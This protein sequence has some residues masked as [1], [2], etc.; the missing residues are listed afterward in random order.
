MLN[1]R[2][3]PGGISPTRSP[4]NFGIS[5]LSKGYNTP[6]LVVVHAQIFGVFKIFLN[7]PA[8]PNGLD[9]LRER[10]P[11]RGEDEVVRLLLWISDTAAD[12]KEVLSI[13][14]PS[15][16]HGNAGPVEEPGAFS[17]FAHRTAMPIALRA[18]DRFDQSRFIASASS[19]C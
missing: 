17:A 7:S 16:Q 10:G 8:G 9:H 3:R 4:F 1:G 14:L 5:T 11:R 2:S 12:E 6:H 18:H 19:R 13:I 15:M